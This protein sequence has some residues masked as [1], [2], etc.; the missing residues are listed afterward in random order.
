MTTAL[1][2]ANALIRAEPGRIEYGYAASYAA[3]GKTHYLKLAERLADHYLARLEG[4]QIPP[5]DFDAPASTID[6]KDSAAAAI[7]AFALLDLA[8]LHPDAAAGAAWKRRGLA[9]LEA[10]CS[11]AF[12]EDDEQRGA[13]CRAAPD[14]APSQSPY[15]GSI[16]GTPR[17]IAA[18]NPAVSPSSRARPV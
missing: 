18:G 6:V 7:V 16:P 12:A 9:M 11:E 3:T 15:C 2:S 1:V 8:H 5:W 13:R 17:R 4:T 14:S 10:L